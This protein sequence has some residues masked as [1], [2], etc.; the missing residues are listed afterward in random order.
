MGELH[1]E[2]VK[3][4]LYRDYGLKVFMGPLQVFVDFLFPPR[5]FYVFSSYLLVYAVT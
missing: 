2:I 3:D 5:I 4:R 1:I